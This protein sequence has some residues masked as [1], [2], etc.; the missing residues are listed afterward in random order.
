MKHANQAG[1]N[2]EDLYMGLQDNGAGRLDQRRC[3]HSHVAL[4][5]LL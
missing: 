4:S 5:G 1:D 3:R 2:N